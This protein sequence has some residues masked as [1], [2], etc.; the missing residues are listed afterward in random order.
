MSI[1]PQLGWLVVLGCILGAKQSGI[2]SSVCFLSLWRL[3]PFHYLSR[4]RRCIIDCQQELL[5]M[6]GNGNGTLKLYYHPISFYSQRVSR[7]LPIDF[8][9][10]LCLYLYL[11]VLSCC[12][13]GRIA[14]WAQSVQKSCTCSLVF[15]HFPCTVTFSRL[16]WEL[17]KQ[18]MK[19]GHS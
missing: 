19:E 11:L 9:K 14:S 12:G 3:L 2:W 10:V 13:V 6:N 1:S 4:P 15:R 7:R 18:G 8:H 16:G 17:S 5:D